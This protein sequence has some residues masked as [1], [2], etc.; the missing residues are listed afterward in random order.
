MGNER[1]PMI[2]VVTGSASGIG[3]ATAELLLERSYEVVGVDLTEGP[4]E[5]VDAPAVTWVKGDVASSETWAEVDAAVRE[6]SND[7][8][9]AFIPCAGTLVTTPLLETDLEDWRRIFDVNVLGTVQGFRTLL[10]AMRRRGGGAV[11]VVAS[12]NSFVV[13]DTLGAYCA[14]KA[15]LLQVVRSAA[16]EY[17][18]DGLRINAVLPGIVDTPLFRSFVDSAADPP[19]I[20]KA[21]SNRVPTG[22][23]ITSREIAE[24]LCFL[25]SDAASAFSGS[26]IVVDGGITTSYS[27]DVETRSGARTDVPGVAG[28]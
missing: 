6:R 11:A 14:S 8:A 2:A 25:I 3:R 7:G 26:A 19:S 16:L 21:L 12:V 27:F 18:G 5:L 10:P 23:L 22:K 17:A 4:K 28:E 15:A 24:V 20:V 13:Q 9:D 1:I